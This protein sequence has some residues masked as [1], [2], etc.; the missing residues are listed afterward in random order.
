MK[1]T[2]TI[3]LWISVAALAASTVVNVWSIFGPDPRLTG[4]EMGLSLAVFVFFIPAYWAQLVLTKHL[5]G[6]ARWKAMFSKRLIRN[7]WRGCPAWLI[8]TVEAVGL[9]WI[10]SFGA[11]YLLDRRCP[12]APNLESPDSRLFFCWTSSA[13]TMAF[14]GFFASAF[15]SA[16]HAE[17]LVRV[18]QNGHEVFLYSK[19]CPKCGSQI[20]RRAAKASG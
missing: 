10:L 14:Y 5:K 17:D 8:K 15:Y 6:R 3:C 20:E 1:P 13:A 19:R 16:L 12:V 4:V 18:C 11:F 7:F 2:L 9:Y